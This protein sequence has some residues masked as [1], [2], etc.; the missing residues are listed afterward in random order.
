MLAAVRFKDYK[1]GECVSVRAFSLGRRFLMSSF[2]FVSGT[3]KWRRW[4]TNRVTSFS[5]FP[6]LFQ[7]SS[8]VEHETHAGY[9]IVPMCRRPFFTIEFQSWMHMFRTRPPFDI[10]SFCYLVGPHLSSTCI[11]IP[12]IIINALLDPNVDFFAHHC[13]LTDYCRSKVLVQGNH[14][15]KPFSHE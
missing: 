2:A 11:N 6:V 12:S 10:H 3:L 4:R 14:D 5:R 7:T 8:M 9:T 1:S 15:W 13:L